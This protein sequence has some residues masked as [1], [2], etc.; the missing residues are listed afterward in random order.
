MR[1]VTLVENT[2]QENGFVAEHGLSLYIEA[3]GQRILFDAGQSRAFADNA[4]RL[5][6][7]LSGVDVAILSHGHY[8]HGG[9]LVHFL[10]LNATAPIY[11]SKYAFD[12][13]Y[14]AVGKDIGLDRVLLNC[15][16]LR[17]TDE[18]LQIAGGL[19]LYNSL[20]CIVPIDSC[21]LQMG[22]GTGRFPDDF[23]HEQYLL[24]EENGKK[25]CISGCSHR[26]IL[27]VVNHFQPDILVGG[28]HL[29]SLAWD[30]EALSMIGN[31]LAMYPTVYYTGHCTGEQQTSVLKEHLRN[32]LH[33][34]STGMEIFI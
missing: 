29:K 26:G 4:V 7:D 23:R 20:R 1:I 34:I 6:V 5:G 28:F 8:D 22:Q 24:I 19:T 10:Q 3:C 15:N 18:G 21:G 27:N 32:R 16:R 17:F 31:Q 30:S 14:N 11:L 13:H 33:C 9:G 12:P 25:I 2:A